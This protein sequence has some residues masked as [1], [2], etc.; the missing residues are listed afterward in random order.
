M[1]KTILITGA[2]GFIGK[3]LLNF[4][5]KNDLLNR[6]NIYLLSSTPIE[7]FKCILHKN[8]T[9]TK[10][11]FIKNGIK[12][13]DTIVHLGAFCPKARADMNN[14]AQ[15]VATINN[16]EY[17]INNLPCIPKKNIYISTISVYGSALINGPVI[18]EQTKPCPDFLYGDAKLFCEKLLQKYCQ[19]NNIEYQILRI[20]VLYGENDYLRKGTIPS[21]IKTILKDEPLNLY[22][23]GSE[24]KHFVHI[25]DCSRIIIES[26]N[27]KVEN[28]IINVVSKETI[29]LLEL[30]K[31]V[32][33]KT[34]K[35]PKINFL[36]KPQ[37]SSD[38][39]FNN[40]ILIK[41][42]GELQI[43]LEKGL[44]SVCKDFINHYPQKIK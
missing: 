37:N 32:G 7:D 9:F 20:G 6:D 8:Y 19:L 35:I 16:C 12:E 44:Q 18:N 17:L 24:T 11:D 30:T 38:T 1:S 2:S 33:E 13:I 21:T 43:P 22:N 14:I 34:N 42:F 10:E 40:N 31:L 29:S 25:D 15:N 3:H 5:I 36:T 39:I 41:N 28:E 27:K 4:A 26:I 23:N